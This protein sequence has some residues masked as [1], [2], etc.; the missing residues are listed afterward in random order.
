MLL[1]ILRETKNTLIY[2]KKKRENSPLFKEMT[3]R[4][5]KEE[6]VIGFVFKRTGGKIFNCLDIE[7]CFSL[8]LNEGKTQK[9]SHRIQIQPKKEVKQPVVFNF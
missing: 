2:K 5:K 1:L 4:R 8:E 3:K 9:N 7:G 6:G